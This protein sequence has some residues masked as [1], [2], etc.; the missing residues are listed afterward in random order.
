MVV[1]IVALGLLWWRRRRRKP[2]RQKDAKFAPIELGQDPP[3]QKP[4]EVSGLSLSRVMEMDGETVVR[5]ELA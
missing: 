2:A 5:H 4:V 1:T 3:S